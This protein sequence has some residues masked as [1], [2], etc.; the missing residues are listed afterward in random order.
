M[1]YRLNV[2]VNVR[3]MWMSLDGVL[4]PLLAARHDG[5]VLIQSLHV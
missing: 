2:N 4:Y 1:Y 3:D 5:I